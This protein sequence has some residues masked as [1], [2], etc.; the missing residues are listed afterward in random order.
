VIVQIAA[1]PLY[2]PFAKTITW[3]STAGTAS[4]LNVIWLS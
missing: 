3:R 1:A 2:L 4:I